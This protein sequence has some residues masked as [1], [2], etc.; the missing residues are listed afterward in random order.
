MAALE[1]K[2]QIV[3]N[4]VRMIFIKSIQPNEVSLLN[5]QMG[6][7]VQNC[8][9][10]CLVYVI[11]TSSLSVLINS[12]IGRILLNHQCQNRSNGA[13]F[14]LLIQVGG[15]RNYHITIS[16]ILEEY[17]RKYYRFCKSK[18]VFHNLTSSLV[19]WRCFGY[20]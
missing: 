1:P 2:N 10:E 19:V 17:V 18:G 12:V 4:E 7:T 11:V 3:I 14:T 6:F 13:D 20:R 16:R 15:L 5:I 8:N 9:V